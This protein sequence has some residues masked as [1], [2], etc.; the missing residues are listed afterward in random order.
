M[1]QK[2]KGRVSACVKR[3]H[4]EQ[5][6]KKEI[7]VFFFPPVRPRGDEMSA[8]YMSSQTA[9]LHTYTAPET[10]KDTALRVAVC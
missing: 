9:T 6:K 5:I 8:T 7:I 2:F 10:R 1:Q 3:G 4:N